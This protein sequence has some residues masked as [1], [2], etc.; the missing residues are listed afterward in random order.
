MTAMSSSESSIGS[1]SDRVL[2]PRRPRRASSVP[3]S[4]SRSMLILNSLSVGSWRTDSAPVSSLRAPRA[5]PRGRASSPG[6]VA[7]VNQRLKSWLR[8]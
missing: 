2:R 4:I 7:I 5:C 1:G 8:R 6:S 3:P